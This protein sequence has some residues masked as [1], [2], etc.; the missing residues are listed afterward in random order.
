MR[1]EHT[2]DFAELLRRAR[3]ATG[4]SQEELAERAG[5]SARAISALERGVNRAPRPD[6]LDML[7]DALALPA[8]E[9]RRWQQVRRQQSSR[10]GDSPASDAG[11]R[12]ASMNNLPHQ[13]TRFFGRHTEIDGLTRMLREAGTQLVTLTG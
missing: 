8:E 11:T 7:A 12:A 6:T 13:P 1:E 9:R 4:L 2:V 10:A 3:R 5:L